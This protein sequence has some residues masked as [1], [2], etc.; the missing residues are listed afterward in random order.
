MGWH[1]V[2]KSIQVQVHGLLSPKHSEKKSLNSF[3][4]M[5]N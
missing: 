1:A 5:G 3:K 2:S 4:A